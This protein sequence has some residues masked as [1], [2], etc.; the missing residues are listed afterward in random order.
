MTQNQDLIKIK[1]QIEETLELIFITRNQYPALSKI[2]ETL[3]S[4]EQSLSTA[5]F[6]ASKSVEEG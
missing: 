6:Y 2:Q 4:T 3:R 5:L 1:E